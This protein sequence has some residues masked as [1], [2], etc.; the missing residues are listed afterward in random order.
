[1]TDRDI[2]STPEPIPM[3]ADMAMREE[4]LE[5]PFVRRAKI[6]RLRTNKLNEAYPAMNFV[7]TKKLLLD[8]ELELSK[9]EVE[10]LEEIPI[11]CV[12]FMSPIMTDSKNSV[13]K[14]ISFT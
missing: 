8:V 9:F 5:N 14:A 2:G 13:N 1:M 7:L 6:L 11:S 4:D 3:N 10:G 12:P